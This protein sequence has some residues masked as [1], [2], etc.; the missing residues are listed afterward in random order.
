MI[1]PEHDRLLRLIEFRQ[2]AIDSSLTQAALD[3][4]RN[5]DDIASLRALLTTPDEVVIQP[6]QPIQPALD[7]APEGTVIKFAPGVHASSGFEVRKRLTLTTYGFNTPLGSRITDDDAGQLA[8]LHVTN[9]GTITVLGTN[10]LLDALA[11]SGNPT[12][13]L[14]FGRVVGQTTYESQPDNITGMRLL[15]IRPTG[16][17]SGARR[18][19][20]LHCRNGTL[21]G[22]AIQ[23]MRRVGEDSLAIYGVN[24]QGP[25]TITDCLLDAAGQNVMFGGDD[26][27]IPSLVPAD[28]SFNDCDFIKDPTLRGTT[29]T[30]KNLF[31]LKVGLRVMVRRSRFRNI[32]DAGQGGYAVMLTVQ[33]QNGTNPAAQV[34]AVMFDDCEFRD[35]AAG[36]N[37]IGYPQVFP[38][39]GQQTRD[40][41]VRDCRMFLNRVMYGGQGW[42][43]FLSREVADVAIYNNYIDTGYQP[44]R[45]TN[46]IYQ[47]GGPVRGLMFY[48]NVIPYSGQSSPYTGNY[49]VSGYWNGTTYHRAVNVGNYFPPNANGEPAIVSNAWGSFPQSANLPSNLH[50]SSAAILAE[51][52]SDGYTLDTGGLATYGPRSSQ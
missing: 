14:N 26:P 21:I 42:P 36:F 40:I 2:A 29:Y 1:D 51:C 38:T 3:I 35:C 23:G 46:I 50:M 8:N 31:E 41:T 22:C 52:N 17:S 10:V 39:V 19:V 49:G 15:F 4:Q 9:N 28:I 7:A 32:W 5:Y 34:G 12:E 33:S 18:G 30:V 37:I 24:G 27:R 44:S 16:T 43:F 25:F 6:G 47:Q 20:G 11:L 48:R 45:S 13:L